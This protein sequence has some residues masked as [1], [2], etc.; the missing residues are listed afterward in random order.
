M[1]S[2]LSRVLDMIVAN[3]NVKKED[4]YKMLL[5]DNAPFPV[6]FE[7][8][9]IQD[10]INKIAKCLD[11]NG[12][13]TYSIDD[14]EYLKNLDMVTILQMINAATYVVQLLRQITTSKDVK[15]DNKGMIDLAFKVLMY[16]IFVPLA[17][18]SSGFREWAFRN[19]NKNLLVQTLETLYNVMCTSE[20]VANVVS[21]IYK[22]FKKKCCYFCISKSKRQQTLNTLQSNVTEHVKQLS[23]ATQAYNNTKRIQALESQLA[24]LKNSSIVTIPAVTVTETVTPADAITTVGT[25]SKSPPK[26]R[27]YKTVRRIVTKADL[28]DASK[29]AVVT[30]PQ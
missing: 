16:A 10:N 11:L 12:D 4:V 5:Q 14:L 24:E 21:S 22:S 13:G 23:K 25:D 8:P 17:E 30:Q 7:S 9:L 27:I 26:Q 15:L 3:P 20:D 1:L 18:N 29:A 19:N 2:V 6:S 28:E